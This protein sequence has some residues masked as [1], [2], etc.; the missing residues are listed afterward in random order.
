MQC[1]EWIKY[2]EG[3][4][5]RM[6]INGQRLKAHIVACTIG[7]NYVRPAGLEAAHKCGFSKCVEKTHLYF[8]TAEQNSLDKVAHNTR[9]TKLTQDEVLEIREKT[10]SGA[11]S[12]SQLSK[13]YNISIAQISRI[14][15]NKLWTHLSSD[16]SSASKTENK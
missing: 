9:T 15:N 3:G 10:K 14:K 7:N 6:S 2:V 1:L 16:N 13:E 11:V 4:Y 8:A 5:G 12:Y